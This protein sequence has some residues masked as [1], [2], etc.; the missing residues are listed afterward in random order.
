M[1]HGAVV[2]SFSGTP[3]GGGFTALDWSIIAVYLLAMV[4]VGAW[5]A[6]RQRSTR[7]YFLSGGRVPAWAAAVSVVATS[8]SAATFIGAPEQ[9]YAGNLTY[10]A[11]VLSS[12]AAV[13]VVAVWFIPAFYRERVTTIYELLERRFGPSARQSC[14][15]AFMVGRLFASG[16]RLYIA[17][18]PLSLIAFGDLSAGHLAASI[19][20]CAVVSILYT[21]LGGLDAVIWTEV[22][23]AFLFVFAA[24]AAIALLLWKI[25][26][27]TG[28]IWSALASTS[29]PD[30]SNKLTVLDWRWD[31]T[32]DFSVWSAFIGL[33]LFNLAVYGTDHDLAQRML[34]C[35]SALKGS[36]SALLSNLLGLIVAGLFLVIGLLLY[37]FYQ[38]AD[39]MGAGVG[40]GAGG[41]PGGG[42]GGGAVGAAAPEGRKVFLSF[43]LDHTPAGVRG[44]MLAGLFAA[45][46]SSLASSMQAMS[47]TLVCDFYRRWRPPEGTPGGRDERHYLVVSRWVSLGWG[48]L[49]A[50]FAVLCIPLQESSGKG[51]IPFAMEVML[52]AYTGMLGVFLTALFTRRGTERSALAALVVGGACVVVFQ[53]GPVAAERWLGW[54]VPVL[55]LGWKMF[56][57][58]AA[59]FAVAAWPGGAREPA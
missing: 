36:Q 29:L 1:P 12:V 19:L 38:R 59:A 46:M 30:G 24:V 58:A 17:A 51:L 47:S 25:P 2:I 6:R 7:D 43:I 41:G 16:A 40:I 50:G 49:L 48:A 32:T 57:G 22:P 5:C 56:G 28:E 21:V 44:L 8:V 15:A 4:G 23:Q 20:I 9:S 45:A 3:Q 39:L 34:T 55:S 31:I 33:T 26:A 10:L 42:A 11:G 13:V 54:Q 37:V 35:K 18:I 27:P 14:S 52:Y 53:F